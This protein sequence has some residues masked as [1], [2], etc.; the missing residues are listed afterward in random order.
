MQ[1][2]RKTSIQR[3][4]TFVIVCTSV[5]GLSLAC[6]SFDL[7]ERS[8]FRREMTGE[9]SVVAETV[10]ANAAAALTFYDRKSAQDVLGALR[11][12]QHI[13]SASLHG[14]RDGG[15]PDET[16]STAGTG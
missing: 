16:D 4:L 9:L 11:A 6:V 15:I 13:T 8:S 7:Y 12:E 14:G 2:L 3:K 5:V 10:G 1:A